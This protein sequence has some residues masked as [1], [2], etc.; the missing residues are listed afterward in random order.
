MDK[1]QESLLY[2]VAFSYESIN[3]GRSQ[4]HHPEWAKVELSSFFLK[5]L[6]IFSTCPQ[7]FLIFFLTLALR[8]GNSPTR[9]GPGYAT[10][11][12]TIQLILQIQGLSKCNIIFPTFKKKC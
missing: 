4:P 3:Q 10:A 7:N 9:E 2:C 11:I 5:F 12:N 6:S 8:V 1:S